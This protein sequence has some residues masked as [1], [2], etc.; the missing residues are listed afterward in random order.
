MSY[1]FLLKF[2]G[3]RPQGAE[4]QNFQRLKPEESLAY[5]DFNSSVLE[6]Q[7]IYSTIRCHN[8]AGLF[9]SK[10]SDG[11]KISIRQPSVKNAKATV[12]PL[13][14]TEYQAGSHYQSN[15]NNVEI[16]WS[17][18]EDHTGIKQFKVNISSS[19]LLVK[20]YL[21]LDFYSFNSCL[22]I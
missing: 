16:I 10:S 19:C 18:F 13:S 2:V 14:I 22:I 6:G 5:T 4:L 17:G 7:T 15:I 3:Y 8:R 11:V 9:S 1:S 20:Y 12:I 21:A